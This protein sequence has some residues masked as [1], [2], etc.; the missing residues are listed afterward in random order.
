MTANT[1]GGEYRDAFLAYLRDGDHTDA[2]TRMFLAPFAYP[3]GGYLAPPEMTAELTQ[4]IVSFSPIR[5]VASTRTIGE[6]SVSYPKRIRNTNARWR[7]E[8]DEHSGRYTP[9]LRIPMHEIIGYVDMANS[10]I[11]DPAA[12]LEQ[13]L[14]LELA[15]DFGLKESLAFVSGREAY[16]PCGVISD[17]YVRYSP[18]GN[19]K[20]IS[21]DMLIGLMDEVPA[22]Y[23]KR[24][25]WL[26]NGN[27]ISTARKLKDGQGNYLWQPSR[28]VGQPET[29]LCRPLVETPD[30]P[31]VCPGSTPIVFGDIATAYRIVD[32]VK[33]KI[34]VD[35][36]TFANKDITRI[37]A[38][39]KVGASIV[40]IDA[41]RKLKC[42][43]T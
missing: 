39:R 40:C 27:T 17:S 1:A 42:S 12:D 18:S 25:S 32:H 26:M 34:L 2:A 24:G 28:N 9:N 5:A 37:Y 43:V 36:N 7:G 11:C 33:M 8:M 16:E 20:E 22:H 23:R 41:I 29:I 38:Y 31:D 10:L 30:M 21:A 13:E 6:T 3:D 14:R 35:K 4:D 19:P 15:Q